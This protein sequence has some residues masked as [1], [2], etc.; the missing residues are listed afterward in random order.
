MMSPVKVNTSFLTF[1]VRWPSVQV[2]QHT[3]FKELVECSCYEYS[4]TLPRICCL[5]CILH[6]G[7]VTPCLFFQVQTSLYV[8]SVCPIT[9]STTQSMLLHTLVLLSVL[10]CCCTVYA[11][12]LHLRSSALHLHL[13]M[14]M[15]FA[16]ATY[17]SGSKSRVNHSSWS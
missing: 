13:F 9:C 3:P 17:G 5:C 6:T 7:S 15:L 14:Q 12:K 10:L 2:Q 16:K 11:P 8:L 1:L 4:F